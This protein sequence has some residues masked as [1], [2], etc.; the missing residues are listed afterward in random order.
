MYDMETGWLSLQIFGTAKDGFWYLV[1]CGF[2]LLYSSDSSVAKLR[3]GHWQ[4]G[5]RS[6]IVGIKDVGMYS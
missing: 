1:I 5:T 4:R 3:A 6:Y 2:V